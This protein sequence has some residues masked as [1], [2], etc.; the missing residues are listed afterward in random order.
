[1]SHL[2]AS[3]IISTWNGRHLLET[4]LPKALRAVAEA[5]G[6]HEVI[7][8]DDASRDDTVAYVKREFPQVRLL[9]LKRN[10]RFAG[11]NNAGARIA[12]GEYLVFLNNDMLVEPDFLEPLLRPFRDPGVFAVTA[13]IH[14][15]PK[16]AGGREIR[17]TGLVRARFED[18]LFVLRHEDLPASC[19]SPGLEAAPAAQEPVPVLYAGGGSSAWR[20]DRFLQLGGFDRLFRPFY[21]ED[22]DVSYRAQKA[23]WKV[24]F[25]PGSQVVHQHRQT[26]NPRNF[27]ARYIE[28]MFGK[29][30]LLFT[31][32]VLTDQTLLNAHFR[33]LWR[34]IVGGG[35]RQAPAQLPAWF[36]RAALQVPEL[37]VKRHRARAR[38]LLSD[39]EVLRQ[40]EAAAAVEAAEAGS[41]PSSGG[42][43]RSGRRI[44]VLGFAPLPFE[45]ERMVD[46][47][48]FR[49]W[50]IAQALNL[51]GHHVT[52]VACRSPGAYERASSR[53]PVLRFEGERL[54]YYSAEREVFEGGQFL[55]QLCDRTQPD[56]IVTVHAYCAWVASRLRT[57]APLWA[58]LDSHAVGEGGEAAM[59]Q[60]WPWER[61]ALTRA[62]AFSVV[63]QR[64][65]HC[66]LGEL[67]AVGRLGAADHPQEQIYYLP[68]PIDNAPYHHTKQVL[69]GRLVSEDDFI[70]LWSGA[71]DANTDVDTL[72][73]GIAAAMREE[74][75]IRFVSLG[76][77]RPGE[78]NAAFYEFRR[79][80]DESDLA[81]RFLF[82]GWMSQ[83]EVPSYY[84]ESDVGISIECLSPELQLGGRYRLVDMMRAGLPVIAT[85]GS[86]ISE[87][88]QDER[89]GL[90]CAPGD[91]HALQEAIL[92]LARD[93]SLRRRCGERA[94]QWVFKH[95]IL[96]EV[97]APLC[98][99]ARNPT[100]AAGR[101][102]ARDQIPSGW[103]PRGRIARF[104]QVWETEGRK[105]T[106]RRVGAGLVGGIAHA[107][108]R[109]FVRRRGT[110]AW[111]LDPREP[112]QAALV[113]RAGGVALTR[114]VVA[115][116]REH[117]PAVDITVLAPEALAAET[118]YE[119]G[120][121]VIPAAGAGLVSYRITKQ[122]VRTLHQ[123]EYDTVVVAGEGNRRAELVAILAGFM[124]RVEVR[125]DGAAHTFGVAP[126]K[127]L[128]LLLMLLL[129]AVEKLTLTALLA[130]VWA[131]LWAEGKIWRLREL[132]GARPA[133][134]PRSR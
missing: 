44:L 78:D 56:A 14:M 22:L 119:T 89:L 13:Q 70:V 123:G 117:Y 82:L 105:A 116:L 34:L 28:R 21:F 127:P 38:L 49:T 132:W 106:L 111:G 51:D 75:R 4:C 57:E 130:L 69:R 41:V 16:Y 8:V 50:H 23:G 43:T 67:A 122:L 93:E 53:P 98:Q 76:G 99:W 24:V 101:G 87:V 133:P 90:T 128:L 126:Y 84:F 58:D 30:N 85:F 110:K 100:P 39:A 109:A 73:A 97:M 48:G 55:K 131:A 94:R 27:P 118:R 96:K 62:D 125:D 114:K 83:E 65:K 9:A 112:P 104:L 120:A 33:R 15:P 88:V 107:L 36:L 113:I 77:A 2:R 47:R 74:A 79:K 134:A 26:N 29:N 18:G 115:R 63:S 68:S 108:A 121:P 61:A 25:A 45:R 5:G 35:R 1:M 10:L 20:R 86:E 7:V 46:S 72:L 92:T 32:K 19:G 129:G 59:A 124:R 42:Q 64:R 81:D 91:P 3:L 11:A 17:E 102:R 12:R 60:G 71:Y 103:H 54:V 52:L 37:L 80:V 6:D 40:G 95:R 31:W 66:L